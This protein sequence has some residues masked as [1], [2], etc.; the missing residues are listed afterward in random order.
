MLIILESNNYSSSKSYGKSNQKIVTVNSPR[1]L[2]LSG[3]LEGFEK[4]SKVDSNNNK[5]N[6]SENSRVLY[7]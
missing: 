5:E 4:K 2:F 7:E 6:S 3:E 1:H